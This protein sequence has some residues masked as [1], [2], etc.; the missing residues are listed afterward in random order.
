MAVTLRLYRV[1]KKGHPTYKIVAVNRR[2]KSNGKYLESVGTY[3]PHT[4]PGEL[5]IVKDRLEY[6]KSK[7][8]IISEGLGKL[9][10]GNKKS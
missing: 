5:N 1:G 6:W 4:D 9:L 7:G 8:A 3:N 10:K 2:Y